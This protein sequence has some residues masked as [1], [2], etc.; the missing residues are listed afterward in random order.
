MKKII[1]TVLS[2]LLLVCLSASQVFAADMISPFPADTKILEPDNKTVIDG[3][4]IFEPAYYNGH[5]Y[6][7]IA[8]LM[9]GR[10]RIPSCSSNITFTSWNGC[11]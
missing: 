8:T 10:R 1:R 2:A 3:D 9:S 4:Q 5:T 7:I 6:Q 11:R